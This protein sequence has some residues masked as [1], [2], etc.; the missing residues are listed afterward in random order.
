MPKKIF[1]DI[2]TLPAD[3]KRW[4]EIESDIRDDIASRYKK[5]DTIQQK[6]E[7]AFRKT[8]LSGEFGRVLCIG[9]VI[10]ED[11]REKRTVL[12]WDDTAKRFTSDEVRTLREWW[13]LLKDFD[14][15]ADLLI[16]HN[17]LNF[18]LRFIYQRSVV[19][20]IRPTVDLNFRRYQSYPIFDTM[21]EWTKWNTQESI[22]LDRLALVLGLQS[23]KTDEISGDKV[24][25]HYLKGN[26]LLICG[27]CLADVVLTREIYYRMTFAK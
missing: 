23:S 2:E 9:L 20:K 27:Y 6:Q 24:Y 16:G 1:L 15:S 12:G 22:S 5:S 8:S 26:H 19:N 25:D 10:D 11:S 14:P 13:D 21:H 4:S 3:E 17:I 18:D 7:E